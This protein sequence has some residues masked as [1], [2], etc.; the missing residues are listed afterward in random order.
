MKRQRPEIGDVFSIQLMDGEFATGQVVGRER[1]V[2]NSI[3]CAFFSAKHTRPS[4]TLNEAGSLISCLFITSDLLRR[5]KWTI[6]GNDVISV[7]Q[8]IQP[9]EHLRSSGWVGAKV[10]GSGIV[11]RF[12]NAFH[13]LD[14]WDVWADPNYLDSLL[15]CQNVKPN[16]L[17][18]KAEQMD[19]PEPE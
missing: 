8:E 17:K 1:E 2:L 4:S 16:Q 3:T 9:Y 11:E 18:L 19:K 7:P 13:G 10:I 6:E 12:L 5:G 15:I 14:Y